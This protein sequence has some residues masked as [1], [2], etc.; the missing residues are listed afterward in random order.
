MCQT[1]NHTTFRDRHP[2]RYATDLS[3]VTFGH[4]G[5]YSRPPPPPPL[6]S[7]ITIWSFVFVFIH[8]LDVLAHTHLPLKRPSTTDW[9]SFL[10]T[11]LVSRTSSFAPHAHLQPLSLLDNQTQPHHWVPFR[12]HHRL[13]LPAFIYFDSSHSVTSGPPHSL[14]S[15]VSDRRLSPTNSSALGLRPLR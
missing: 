13:L 1:V 12:H 3:E 7:A 10:S 4:H 9:A 5:L 14:G 15:L 6:G 11:S 8:R 2:I